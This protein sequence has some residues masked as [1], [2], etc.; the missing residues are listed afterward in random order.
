MIT[1]PCRNLHKVSP[2]EGKYIGQL[3][4]P[5]P[6]SQWFKNISSELPQRKKRSEIVA[7][8]SELMLLKSKIS[9]NELKVPIWVCIKNDI[10]NV[11]ILINRIV[12]FLFIS[13]CLLLISRYIEAIVIASKTDLVCN[14]NNVIKAH[15]NSEIFIFLFIFQ[16]AIKGNEINT[17]YEYMFLCENDDEIR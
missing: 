15:E 13:K 8:L 6:K 12:V 11:E 17:T 2:Y 9:T 4:I 3:P 16:I 10:N 5:T 7:Y 1:S 14:V